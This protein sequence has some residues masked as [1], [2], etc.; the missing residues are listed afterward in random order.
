M[1]DSVN[2]GSLPNKEAIAYFKQKLVIPSK[3]WDELVGPIHAKAFTVAGATTLDIVN[4]FYSS[5]NSYIGS[6]KSLGNFLHDFDDIV[7][8]HG[9]SYKGERKWRAGLMLNT[10][11]RSA[12]AAGRWERFQRTKR[13]R[14][15]LIYMTV[16]DEFVRTQ[17]K[18]WHLHVYHIDDPFW[19][20]HYPPNGWGCRCYVRSASKK[21]L[22][23]LGLDVSTSTP[24]QPIDVVNSETGAKTKKLPGIDIGWDYN[25]GKAW[26]APDAIFGQQ[27]M[28]VPKRLRAQALNAFDNS[29]YDKPYAKLTNDTVLKVAKGQKV[30]HGLAQTV[31]FLS[32]DI[33]SHLTEQ[34]KAPIGAAIIV[35]EGDI[36]HWLRDAKQARGAAIPFSVASMVPKIIREPGAVLFDGESII[37]AHQLKDGRYAKFVL[38]VNIKDKLKHNK[39]RFK[40]YLNVFKTAGIVLAENLK[41][42]RYKVISGGIE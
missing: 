23:R 4:D 33:I 25:V 10:N 2:Y 19:K 39:S 3:Q 26:L 15:Y 31:G 40:E 35:R 22:D 7:A 32:E 6:G 30:Q 41:E 37:Y 18:A 29:I 24:V 9:W 27:L 14:P 38:K 13:T 8:K 42:P 28:E 1:P 5:V 11:K 21:D 34:S 36:A 12:Y 20:T 17:H 16:G